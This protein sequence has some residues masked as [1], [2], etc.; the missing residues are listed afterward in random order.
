MKR[1]WAP[2]LRS[3]LCEPGRALQVGHPPAIGLRKAAEARAE[4]SSRAG[5]R[6]RHLLSE[7]E[8]G[9]STSRWKKDVQRLRD[10]ALNET[11]YSMRLTVE[12]SYSVLTVSCLPSRRRHDPGES[13]RGGRGDIGSEAH[14]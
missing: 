10:V 4:C 1:T 3:Q 13:P 6:D 9:C 2:A 7:V 14:E 8:E 5:S 12:N 11:S